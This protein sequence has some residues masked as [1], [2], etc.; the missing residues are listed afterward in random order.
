MK[1]TCIFALLV[2]GL[3]ASP[4]AR[5]DARDEAA[6][7]HY[8]RGMKAYDLGRFDEAIAEFEKAYELSSDPVLLFNLAQSQRRAGSA[9][10][11]L[12]FY[13]RFVKLAPTSPVRDKAEVRIAELEREIEQERAKRA[14]EASAA[15]PVVTAPLAPVPPPDKPIRDE[16]SEEDIAARSRLYLSAGV[17]SVTFSKD[18]PEPP[19]APLFR[20]ELDRDLG[21]APLRGFVGASVAVAT[22]DEASASEEN[23]AW[24]YAAAVQGGL[25]RAVS[26]GLRLDG[27]LGVG[28]SW[29]KLPPQNWFVPAQAKATGALPLLA[30]R[31]ALKSSFAFTNQTSVTLEGG[32]GLAYPLDDLL[33]EEAGNL[34]QGEILAGIEASF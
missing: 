20:L 1:V 25:R 31:A 29:L 21:A 19:L 33:S 23:R 24:L 16:I 22:F 9:E 4:A 28:M 14:E 26:R 17:A 12:F 6:E 8:D 32:Y 3:L 11:A 13:R 2:N 30:L 34:R 7:Q 15:E 5:A 10:R 18:V 27:K